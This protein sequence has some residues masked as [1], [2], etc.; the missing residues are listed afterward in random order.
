MK[1]KI[2]EAFNNLGIEL[3]CTTSLD[4]CHFVDGDTY[5]SW[6]YDEAR[7]GVLKI[8]TPDVIWCENYSASQIYGLLQTINSEYPFLKAFVS[9]NCVSL[10]YERE[11]MPSDKDLKLVILWMILNLKMGCNFAHNIMKKLTTDE[12]DEPLTAGE[13]LGGHEFVDLGLSVKWATCNVGATTPIDS[14]GLYAWGE[15]DVKNEYEEANSKTFGKSM[16]DIA[17]NPIYD[18]ARAKWGG[19]WRLPTKE[20][21]NEL[22][23][24]CTWTWTTLNGVDGQKLTSK[25]NGNSIFFPATGGNSRGTGLYWSSTPSSYSS[26]ESY[27]FWFGPYLHSCSA[28]NRSSGQSVRPVSD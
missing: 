10:S 20:E 15:T 8:D 7:T 14:G 24:N 21:V 22:F 19:S 13:S 4:V 26:D 12:N 3:R 25:I 9:N 17:G 18:V 5:F 23:D 11:L 28:C 16:A 1:E 2:L 27:I 6:V